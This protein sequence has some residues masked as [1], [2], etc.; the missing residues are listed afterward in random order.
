MAL[1]LDKVDA[2]GR[3][4]DQAKK[5][6]PSDQEAAGGL[7]LVSLLKDGKVTKGQ[8]RKQLDKRDGNAG[9]LIEKNAKTAAATGKAQ[10]HR[11]SMKNLVALEQNR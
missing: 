2:A 3:L 10:F 11:D 8:L 1:M 7:K 9:L 4:F 5:V 6:D